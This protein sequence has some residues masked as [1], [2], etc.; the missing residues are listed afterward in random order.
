[1]TRHMTI[2]PLNLL[3]Q[4]FLSGPQKRPRADHV[5]DTI[6]DAVANWQ[7]RPCN[8]TWIPCYK[9]PRLWK[10]TDITQ[11]GNT[12][13]FQD[14]KGHMAVPPSGMYSIHFHCR[15]FPAIQCQITRRME[16]E[17]QK[18]YVILLTISHGSI[19]HL[20]GT[21]CDI[22]TRVNRLMES[23]Q[24]CWFVVLSIWILLSRTYYLQ[25]RTY[26]T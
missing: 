21:L 22:K 1:M 8:L 9:N 7:K 16:G 6:N 26:I 20:F 25:S 4:A 17:G 5:V 14:A 13:K 2:S 3:N 23:R 18:I 10:P 24:L 11:A 15:N 19:F 12:V